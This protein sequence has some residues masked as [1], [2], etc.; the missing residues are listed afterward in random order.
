[1]EK[2]KEKKIQKIQKFIKASN[3]KCRNVEKP[4]IQKIQILTQKFIKNI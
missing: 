4:E 2:K 3:K 1:M